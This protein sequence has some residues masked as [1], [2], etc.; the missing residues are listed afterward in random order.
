MC[1]CDPAEKYGSEY[2]QWIGTYFAACV[3]SD[4]QIAAFWFGLI[5]IFCWLWAQVPQIVENYRNQKGE[6][7]SLG[8]LLTWLLGDITNLIG[9]IYTHQF[10]TQLYTAYYFLFMDGVILLQWGYY[11]RKNRGKDLS[12]G[13]Y[14]MVS[15][16][17][18]AKPLVD[19]TTDQPPAPAPANGRSLS[20][21]NYL[22]IAAFVNIGVLGL[23]GLGVTSMRAA[24]YEAAPGRVLLGRSICDS[25][26][27]LSNTENII[28]SVSAWVSGL[29]YFTA[30]FPQ[31]YHNHATKSTEGLSVF[32]FASSTAANVFYT[33]S[34]IL[35][36]STD[37]NSD[38]F[39]KSTFAYLL[40]SGGTIASTVPILYQFHKYRRTARKS[41]SYHEDLL[42]PDGQMPA[43]G[44]YARL[45]DTDL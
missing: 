19:V 12:D 39:W 14:F 17:G 45:E 15:E 33:L 9:C 21:G 18:S 40:G 38:D 13:E 41:D 4:R 23:L 10:Q 20:S 1:T 27:D 32:M 2:V 8:F 35:P 43:D 5:N 26:P 34:I 22:A 16:D 29:L 7:L 44:A 24:A 3:Y 25:S 30:R 37:Y 6:A 28:G 42:R 31:I 11:W 36:E